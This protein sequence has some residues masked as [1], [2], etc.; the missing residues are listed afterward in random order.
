[1]MAIKT[2]NTI[3]VIPKKVATL[4]IIKFFIE[5]CTCPLL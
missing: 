2:V 4:P 5:L 1:M 3:D